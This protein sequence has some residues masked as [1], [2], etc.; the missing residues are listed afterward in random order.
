M[1]KPTKLMSVKTWIE[2]ANEANP[3]CENECWRV[4]NDPTI[5]ICEKYKEHM[6]TQKFQESNKSE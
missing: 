4:G 5:C 2:I 1:L 6:M 3:L